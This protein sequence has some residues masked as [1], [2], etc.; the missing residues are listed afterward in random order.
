MM[1]AGRGAR[2]VEDDQQPVNVLTVSPN[3]YTPPTKTLTHSIFVGVA[4][5]ESSQWIN[6]V[7]FNTGFLILAHKTH[8]IHKYDVTWNASICDTHQLAEHRTPIVY[9]FTGRGAARIMRI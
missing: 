6:R 2:L 7:I 5:I 4:K 9:I 8:I 3:S 1:G